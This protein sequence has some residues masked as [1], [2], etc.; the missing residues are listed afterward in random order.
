MDEASAASAANAGSATN[1]ASVA[2][3]VN[4]ASAAGASKSASA[5]SVTFE[6]ISFFNVDFHSI[7][8]Q[9]VQQVQ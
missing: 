1:A 5:V 3:A 9:R 7:G 2:S 8:V 4:A 6:D